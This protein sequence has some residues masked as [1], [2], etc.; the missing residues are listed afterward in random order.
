MDVEGWE[1]GHR[2]AYG[3]GAW[4]RACQ[5]ARVL[6]A[7]HE[8]HDLGFGVPAARRF[9]ADPGWRVKWPWG[10]AVQTVG[11]LHWRAAYEAGILVDQVS[12]GDAMRYCVQ[13]A[14]PSAAGPLPDAARGA[15]IGVGSAAS[16]ARSDPYCRPMPGTIFRNRA[17]PG[18][19]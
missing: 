1:S 5:Q 4:E 10:N 11:L 16:V 14:D 9:Y 3:C 7:W 6:V 2:V 19:N 13:G 15:G 18:R 17:P 12:L 8:E